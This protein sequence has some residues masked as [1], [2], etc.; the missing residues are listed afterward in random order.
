[1]LGRVAQAEIDTSRKAAVLGC[2]L[3]GRAFDEHL[4]IEINISVISQA[5]GSAQIR[6][7]SS[8]VLVGVK[9]ISCPEYNVLYPYKMCACVLEPL[10]ALVALLNVCL[11]AALFVLPVRF[12]V[13][14]T[15]A[16]IANWNKANTIFCAQ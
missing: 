14:R 7:G 8:H 15:C 12:V 6:L 3:D 1:M 2:R 13:I 4:P 10:L 5:L 11:P 9:V 16:S